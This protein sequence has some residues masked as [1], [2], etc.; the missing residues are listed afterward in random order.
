MKFGGT[1]VEDVKCIKNVA[2]KIK[3]QVKKKYKVAVVVSAM[4]GTTDKLID[5]VNQTSNN[6]INREYDVVVSSGEQITAGLMAL[7]LQELNV[8]A[9]S[10]QGWQVPLKTTGNHGVARI[11]EISTDNIMKKFSEG[12]KV[13]V[14]AGFQGISSNHRER[15][16]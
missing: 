2:K 1:S 8:P 12:M 10:W 3:N 15:E 13:A 16:L 11:E 6:F 7:T 5:F 14:I 4:A 9:R